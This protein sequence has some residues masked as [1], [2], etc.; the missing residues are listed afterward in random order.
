MTLD[1]RTFIAAGA[2]MGA[3]GLVPTP[4]AEGAATADALPGRS[5]TQAICCGLPASTSA[6]TAS[7]PPRGLVSFFT[8]VSGG[9]ADRIGVTRDMSW[10][11]RM[12]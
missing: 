9:T 4:S 2:A 11:N 12:W 5:Y 10:P 1:R 3:G 7:F 8:V 6:Y